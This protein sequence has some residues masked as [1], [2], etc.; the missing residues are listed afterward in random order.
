MALAIQVNLT[1]L[2]KVIEV[3]G[4]VAFACSGFIEARRR[5]MDIR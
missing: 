1:T 5:D 3:L 2:L 4:I